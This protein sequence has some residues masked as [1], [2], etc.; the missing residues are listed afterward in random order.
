MCSIFSFL[1]KDD[2]PTS[3]DAL[4]RFPSKKRKS[5][6]RFRETPRGEK[7]PFEFDKTPRDND[8]LESFNIE[9]DNFF[10]EQTSMKGEDA[11]DV[12]GLKNKNLK[13]ASTDFRTKPKT[14]RRTPNPRMIFRVQTIGLGGVIEDEFE[15]N[16]FSDKPLRQ[17][18]HKRRKHKDFRRDNIVSEV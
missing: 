14:A 2:R 10:D 15:P 16:F 12:Q 9:E 17:E 4:D 1:S 13:K 5:S 8:S 7:S 18:F 6:C 3:V 11:F